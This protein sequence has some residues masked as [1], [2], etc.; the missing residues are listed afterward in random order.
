MNAWRRYAG[1]FVVVLSLTAA[2]QVPYDLQRPDRVYPL[3]PELLEV[4]AL[5]DVDSMTIACLHD[6]AAM[7]YLFDL[8]KGTIVRRF[9]FGHPGD[10]EGLT[11]V[12]KDYFALRSDGLVY[13]M[14]LKGDVVHVSDTFRLD[15][16]NRNIEGLGYDERM[17]LVLVSPKDIEKGA[18]AARDKRVLYAFDPKRNVALADPVLTLSVDRLVAQARSKGL[19]VPMRT[20]ESGREVPALKLRLS[21]V[22]VDPRSDLYYLLSAVDR[23]LVVVDRKGELVH[24]QQLDAKL[25]PKPEGITF[26]PQGDLLISNEGKGTAPNI[27]RYRRMNTGRSDH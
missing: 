5:T 6:E 4:S 25:F 9:S 20:T 27:I 17:Q 10:L 13:R 1:L 26:L 2:A 19:S 16:P 12:G 14:S 23:V 18:P 15:L 8:R 22:A 7:M 21:S 24:L 3:P 11:R